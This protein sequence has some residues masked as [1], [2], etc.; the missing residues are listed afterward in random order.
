MTR[1]AAWAWQLVLRA[2]AELV[3]SAYIKPHV[4]QAL[5][6]AEAEMLS[7]RAEGSLE[8]PMRRDSA[9]D[10]HVQEEADSLPGTSQTV[11]APAKS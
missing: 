9:A 6:E 7:G 11:H 8:A 2:S 10:L 1:Q 5:A 4:L 3:G